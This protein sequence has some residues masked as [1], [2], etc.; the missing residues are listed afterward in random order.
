MQS[1]N[2][3]WKEFIQSLFYDPEFS[4]RESARVRRTVALGHV[5]LWPGQWDS[6]LVYTRETGNNICP[7]ILFG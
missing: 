1:S 2:H 4:L 3:F 5:G 7:F 6:F